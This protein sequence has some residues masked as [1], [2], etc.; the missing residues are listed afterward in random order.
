MH[1]DYDST[2]TSPSA[3]STLLTSDSEQEVST[4]FLNVGSTPSSPHPLPDMDHASPSQ[5]APFSTDAWVA[6]TAS[7]DPYPEISTY[8]EVQHDSDV[9]IFEVKKIKLRNNGVPSKKESP[10]SESTFDLTT[11]WTNSDVEVVELRE[12]RRTTNDLAQGRVTQDLRRQH[13]RVTRV[14]E[15]RVKKK[16]RPRG[17]R[18]LSHNRVSKRPR[19]SFTSIPKAD[20]SEERYKLK[21]SRFLGDLVQQFEP[22]V[23]ENCGVDPTSLTDIDKN[24]RF[25]QKKLKEYAAVVSEANYRSKLRKNRSSA[26]HSSLAQPAD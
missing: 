18:N 4:L 5:D 9:D 15:S 22:N 26:E 2:V 3:T 19:I 17:S 10:S 16:S 23:Y 24:I 13:E 8:A 21:S 14:T 11:A 6:V 20:S 1:P 7:G 12:Q 25:H